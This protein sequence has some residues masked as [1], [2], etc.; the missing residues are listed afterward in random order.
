MK[1]CEIRLPGIW[2]D[3]RKLDYPFS[4]D[5]LDPGTESTTFIFSAN[6]KVMV[7]AAVI[8][9]SL[10]NYLAS[11]GQTVQLVFEDGLTG[12]MG[13]LNRLG[14]FDLLSRSIDTTP[15][16]PTMS[17]AKVY[18]GTN[19]AVVELAQIS[20]ARRD[21]SLPDRL[22]DSLVTA[23]SANL[24]EKEKR[25]LGTAAYTVFAELIDNVYEHV[26]K[27]K[28]APQLDAFAA[29]QVY[30]RG[31][32]ARVVVSDS[33]DGILST[34]RPSLKSTRYAD[35][36]DTDLVVEIFEKGI[37]RHGEVRGCGLKK[38]AEHAIRYNARLNLRLPQCRVYLVP[39]NS[40]YAPNTAYC[41]ADLP[42]I[43][44]THLCFDFS[45]D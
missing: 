10:A 13:Y 4:G 23:Q 14:F 31:K 30:Q 1:E 39:S 20:P 38:S 22:S 25:R 2:I 33:G 6:C 16:R 18:A 27:N 29:L 26:Y 41:R 32:S 17:A 42:H 28:K 5:P 34:L 43:F 19:I 21:K 15:T 45:L 37:S 36:D 35:L 9:L 24:S 11:I 40:Q 12:T 44:G 3:A 7:D 8:I